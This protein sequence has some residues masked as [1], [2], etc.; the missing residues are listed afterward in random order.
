MAVDNSTINNLLAVLA[1]EIVAVYRN[2]SDIESPGI[3]VHICVL[4]HSFSIQKDLFPG[5]NLKNLQDQLAINLKVTRSKLESVDDA[6]EWS[7]HT[8]DKTEK[9]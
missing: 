8:L 3:T 1:S 6:N 7:L 2:F 9:E 5:A 4:Q